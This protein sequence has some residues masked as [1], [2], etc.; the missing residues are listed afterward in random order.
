LIRAGSGAHGRQLAAV[1]VLIGVLFLL[2]QHSAISGNEHV[3]G[4]GDHIALRDVYRK[5]VNEL[6][7]AV[8]EDAALQNPHGL[9]V[10]ARNNVRAPQTMLL[11]ELDDDPFDDLFLDQLDIELVDF[12][13]PQAGVQ[14]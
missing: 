14:V 1:V 6:P 3:D 10:S 4:V 13:A 9:H 11:P 12:H 8:V 7:N 2:F 5:V